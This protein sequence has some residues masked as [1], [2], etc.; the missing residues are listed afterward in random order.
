MNDSGI[1]RRIKL[2]SRPE[3]YGRLYRF[4]GDFVGTLDD[5]S[6]FT[7]LNGKELLHDLKLLCEEWFTNVMSH[8]YSER[9]DGKGFLEVCL[10]M[11]GDVLEITFR[12][13][14]PPFNPLQEG[15]SLQK[16][17]AEGGM[18]IL[19]IKTLTSKQVY[20]REISGNVLRL[21]WNL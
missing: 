5:A 8:A 10:Q 12:D 16:D 14:G 2:E 13:D 20:E 15:I 17:P 11:A 9:S 19:I 7:Q 21:Q 3:E 4:L 6:I 1:T 18:G